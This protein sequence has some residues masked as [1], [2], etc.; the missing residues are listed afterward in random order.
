MRNKMILGLNGYVLSP[1]GAADMNS[2]D[3]GWGGASVTSTAA[4]KT[5]NLASSIFAAIGGVGNA[6]A[7]IFGGG[8]TAQPV[9]PSTQPS[10]A[11]QIALAQAQA[12]ARTQGEVSKN[13]PLYV[14]AG[15]GAL[16]L[17]TLMT[18]K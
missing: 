8:P 11:D 12:A 1:F 9:Q 18:R 14:G 10:I 4:P 3:Y 13:I 6:V 16:L 2:P 5:D 17:I 15:L 7:S